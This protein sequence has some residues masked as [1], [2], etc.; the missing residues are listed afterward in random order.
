[1]R[2]S[3]LSERSGV[4]P[5]SLRYYEKQGL[6]EAARGDN[7]YRDYD[8][9]AIERASTIRLL[10][11]LGFP[12]PVVRSVLAC[13]GVPEGDSVHVEA[14]EQLERVRDGMAN[15]IARLTRAHSMV[16]EFLAAESYAASEPS[17]RE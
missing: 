3:E 14:A 6:I 17:S 9:A 16:T 10:F 1:M 12:R 5:R 11:G 13:S 2:I 15:E 8:E 4:S 7:G